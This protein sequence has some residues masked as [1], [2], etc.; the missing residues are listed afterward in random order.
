MG[1]TVTKKE[2]TR[3]GT[4]EPHYSRRQQILAKYPQ[5]RDLYGPD[6]A[7]LYWVIAYV[8]I[9]LFF[10]ANASALSTWQYW[11]AAYVVGGAITH[12]LSLACHELSHNLCFSE[13]IHNELLAIVANFAQGLPSCITFKKYH[14][15]HHYYQGVDDVDVDIPTTFEGKFFTNTIMKVIW[16]FLQPVFYA[17]RPLVVKPKSMKPMELVNWVAVV[18][19]NIV[20][21]KMYG[22]SAVGFNILSTLLGMGLHPCAGHFIAEHYEF[23]KLQETYSYYGALNILS[24]NVG[25]HNEH[26]DF[27]KIAGVNLPKVREIA[28]EFYTDL[29]VHESW[30]KVIYDYIIRPD[31]G[32][33]SRIKRMSQRSNSNSSQLS[34]Q[35]SSNADK[36]KDE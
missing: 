3:V 2:F 24:F 17:I 30:V 6:M 4:D 10:A 21:A 36:A 8:A 15:E 9:Q 27:P 12:S 28:S 25:Y 23:K 29:S 32:P 34:S 7:M 33:F 31:V 16:A 35:N 14:L 19:F 1:Q 18:V 13:T 22:A 11:L 26:H 20:F 5:I